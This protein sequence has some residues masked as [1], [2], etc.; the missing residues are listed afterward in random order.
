M[1][2]PPRRLVAHAVLLTVTQ[3]GCELRPRPPATVAEAQSAPFSKVDTVRPVV[4][5]HQHLVSRAGA[6]AQDLAYPTPA[7]QPTISAADLIARLDDAGIQRAVVLS[8][9]FWFDSRR[10]EPSPQSYAKVRAENDWAAAQIAKYPRRLVGFCSFNPLRDHALAE[11]ER[12]ART[13][14][15]IGVKLHFEAS[16]V[17]LGNPRHLASVQKVFAGA[18]SRRL[19]I[20]VHVRADRSYGREQAEIFLDRVLP[21]AP[22]VVVQIAHLW[23]GGAYSESALARYADAVA[24]REPATKNLYFDVTDAALVAERSPRILN[25]IATRIRQI[26]PG[27]VLYGSDAVDAAHPP[28]REAWAAFRTRVPLTEEEFRVIAGNLAPYLP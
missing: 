15:F 11:L 5:H 25:T 8:V 23:G 26:G 1:D 6:A 18:N 19:A 20:I 7:G 27:R 24:S 2:R 13:P 22:D 16:G 4:D 28:P 9:A 17:N 10:D 14:H 3:V 12:C 21:M